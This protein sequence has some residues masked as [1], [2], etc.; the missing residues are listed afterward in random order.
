MTR[1]NEYDNET[2][3]TIA[4]VFAMA[5]VFVTIILALLVD[6]ILDR[7]TERACVE[8]PSR[9]QNYSCNL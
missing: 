1:N 3:I 4:I 9:D 7:P 8:N 2:K 6:E 5:L